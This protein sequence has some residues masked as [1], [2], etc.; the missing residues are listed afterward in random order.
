MVPP[1]PVPPA[2]IDVPK[3]IAIAWFG[4]SDPAAT[5]TVAAPKK[6]TVDLGGTQVST[7]ET[8]YTNGMKMTVTDHPVI[9]GI[10]GSGLKADEKPVGLF[11]MQMEGM[12]MTVTRVATDASARLTWE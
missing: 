3:S 4:V 11:G 1:R 9:A 2:A 8:S 7:T 6:A 10:F 12:S 5:M